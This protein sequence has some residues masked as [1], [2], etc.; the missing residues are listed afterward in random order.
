MNSP[1]NELVHLDNEVI[2][3]WENRETFDIVPLLNEIDDYPRAFKDLSALRAKVQQDDY[4]YVYLTIRDSDGIPEYIYNLRVQAN[5]NDD[6]FWETTGLGNDWVD[7]GLRGQEAR[8]SFHD[9]LKQTEKL[10]LDSIAG[11]SPP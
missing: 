9:K 7:S 10:N 1:T 5:E 11:S 8:N 3:I 6:S 2:N 4:I